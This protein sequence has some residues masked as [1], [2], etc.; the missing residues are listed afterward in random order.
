MQDY[1]FNSRTRLSIFDEARNRMRRLLIP[2]QRIEWLLHV[3][4]EALE[5]SQLESSLNCWQLLFS[6]LD[7]ASF[8]ELV[9]IVDGVF[10]G[11]GVKFEL[12]MMPGA[13]SKSASVLCLSITLTS[14]SRAILLPLIAEQKESVG[15]CKISK[16]FL[17]S[18]TWMEPVYNECPNLAFRRI[19]SMLNND[20]LCP[21]PL[22]STGFQLPVAV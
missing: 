5:T 12:A 19:T 15:V 20:P 7:G 13:S 22:T 6:E 21:P 14:L 10:R 18:N 17:G 8:Q 9:G 3:M 4:V 16:P 11:R 1:N 2:T